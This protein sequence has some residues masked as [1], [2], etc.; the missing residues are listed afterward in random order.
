MI[1]PFGVDP[2]GLQV[3]YNYSEWKETIDEYFNFEC[4]MEYG[5][6]VNCSNLSEIRK[7][8]VRIPGEPHNWTHSREFEKTGRRAN[9]TTN[10]ND[11]GI[12]YLIVSVK[13]PTGL[14]DYQNVTI[15]VYDLPV[16]NFTARSIYTDI[17]DNWGS[18]EDPFILNG[19]LSRTGVIGDGKITLFLWNDTYEPFNISYSEPYLYIP[20][21]SETAPSYT[22]II[23]TW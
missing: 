18:I 21:M 19:S 17:H 8:I 10:R 15:L 22:N 23:K 3:E 16:A 1:D 20:E 7:C 9:Y 12:H 4:C 11:T 2:D 6:T 5:G 13:D 14:I